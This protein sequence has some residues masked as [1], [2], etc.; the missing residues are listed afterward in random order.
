MEFIVYYLKMEQRVEPLT[1]I[2]QSIINM[3]K[4]NP[5][6]WKEAIMQMLYDKKTLIEPSGEIDLSNDHKILIHNSNEKK[7][8]TE[9]FKDPI[10]LSKDSTE[11]FKDPIELFKD[12]TEL[13]KDPDERKAPTEPLKSSNEKKIPDELSKDSNEKKTIIKS[14]KGPDKTKTTIDLS[15][16]PEKKAP[17]ELCKGLNETIEIFED[18]ILSNKQRGTTKRDT[19]FQEIEYDELKQDEMAGNDSNLLLLESAYDNS[20]K[21]KIVFLIRKF[22]TNILKSIL[23]PSK[24]LK[25]PSGKRLREK[26]RIFNN[27][28]PLKV[29]FL[30]CICI[31]KIS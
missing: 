8:P 2:E 22:S 24:N 12:P 21:Y 4:D 20:G 23:V 17:T 29:T 6:L 31:K 9:L 26:T 18:S 15:N 11:L 30:F 1:T 27:S 14:S 28:Q 13:S 25:M 16:D 19:M 5:S 7:K 3:I 10:E